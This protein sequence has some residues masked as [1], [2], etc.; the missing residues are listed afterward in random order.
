MRRLVI[1]SMML[2]GLACWFSVGQVGQLSAACKNTSLHFEASFDQP[3]FERA[4]KSGNSKRGKK[5]NRRKKG[6]R[7]GAKKGGKKNLQAKIANLPK[8]PA[9][10]LSSLKKT[11]PRLLFTS[12]DQERISKLAKRDKLLSQL[13]ALNNHWADELLKEPVL[14]LKREDHVRMLSVFREC[15]SRVNTL[16]LAYRLT[17]EKKYLTRCFAELKNAGELKNWNP[18]HF[19]DTGEMTFAFAVG[20]DWLYDG[21]TKKQRAFLRKA[22]VNKGLRS[23]LKSYASGRGWPGRKNNWNQVCNAGMVAGALA[24]ADTNPKIAAQIIFC[25]TKSAPRALKQYDPMGAY[26]EGPGYWYYG[27]TYSTVMLD[28]LKTALGKDM[29]LGKFKGFSKTALFNIHMTS[30]TG[31]FFNYADGGMRAKSSPALFMLAKKYNNPTWSWCFRRWLSSHY[32]GKKITGFKKRNGKADRF[33]A[34]NIAWYDPR[35]AKPDSEKLPLDY[36]FKGQHDVATMRSAWG[37]KQAIFVGFKGGDNTTPHGHLDAGS[38]VFDSDGVRW[39]YDLGGDNYNLPGYWTR[40]NNKFNRWKYFRLINKSHNTLVVDGQLQNTR[41]RAKIVKFKSTPKLVRALTNL[42]AVYKNQA[43]SVKRGLSFIDRKT[44]VIQDEI[45]N[46]KGEIRWGMMTNAKIKIE[47]NTATLT[48]AGKKMRMRILS[49]AGAKFVVESAKPG[50]K[51]EKQ[52]K[53]MKMLAVRVMPQKNKLTKITIQLQ[54]ESAGK[55]F[56]EVKTKPLSKW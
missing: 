20:Y 28:A 29:G 3:L 26:M 52:N 9:G 45:I 39:A 11:H 27:T 51:K 8:P 37:N 32:F 15:L 43:S 40:K 2:I 38:F 47:G 33:F 6:R 25:A 34:F 55:K 30:P 23:G 22:I 42:T 19:L 54:P 4:R 44:V 35:G 36:F 24:V 13:I 41:G 14:R 16:A 53:N 18:K 46:A 49:P 10:Y 31:L 17:G 12:K 7:K 1:L 50:T 56:I 48:R 21:L 5:N